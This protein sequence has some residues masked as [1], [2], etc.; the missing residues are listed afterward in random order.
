M[1]GKVNRI[2]EID[3][4]TDNKENEPEIV[5]VKDQKNYETENLVIESH[6]HN[7]DEI[8]DNETGNSI[9]YYENHEP[10]LLVCS[11]MQIND[12]IESNP[13]QMNIDPEEVEEIAENGN[14][15][16]VDVIDA[17]NSNKEADLTVFGEMLEAGDSTNSDYKEN[18]FQPEDIGDPDYIESDDSNSSGDSNGDKGINNEAEN[19]SKPE[20]KP[21]AVEKIR[22][23]KVNR[24]MGK[25]YK[26]VKGKIV[27]ARKLKPLRENCRTQCKNILSENVRMAIF[28]EYWA[29]GNHDRRVSFIAGLVGVQETKINRKKQEGKP[30]KNRTNTYSYK[31]C[32]Q[33]EEKKV[34]KTCFCNTLGETEKFVTCAMQN[35]LMTTSGAT[36]EDLRGKA[37]PPHK[38][39]QYKLSQVE[40][41]I[42][43]F[44]AYK[45]H[46]SRRDTNINYLPSHLNITTMYDLYREE[47]PDNPVSINI[48]SRVFHTMNLKFKKPKIDTCTKCDTLNAKIKCAENDTEKDQFRKEL[49]DH[50]KTADD[51]YDSKKKDKQMGL[52]D[53]KYL[54]FAFDLQQVLPTP[55]LT[56]SKMFYLRQLSTYN[57]TVHNCNNGK[58]S[59]FM[60][61]ECTASRGANE[62]ASCLY[63]FLQ[64]IPEGVEHAIFYSDTC[65]GQNK[66]S[67]VISMFQ[68]AINL[69]STLKI[70]DHKFLVPGHTHLECDVDHSII[71]RSKKRSP[72][73]IH[74]PRDW[75][76]LVRNASKKKNFTVF[77]MEIEHFYAFS[78]LQ[79]G[80]GP[81]QKKTNFKFKDVCWLRYTKSVTVNYKFSLQEDEPFKEVSFLR[82]GHTLMQL[83]NAE[84]TTLYEG[85]R[86]INPLKKQNL[87][88]IV[89]LLDKE[90]QY[91]YQNLKTDK[92]VDKDTDPDVDRYVSDEEE[93]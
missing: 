91:F 10:P 4:H 20:S 41:H 19:D 3:K 76:Q 26:T 60:W 28:R 85:P 93:S 51:A 38:T 15:L 24:N 81:L 73:E 79:S 47:Y 54:T 21:F 92:K 29:L 89:D 53:K 36:H 87:L 52:E 72:I 23:R 2:D 63:R 86:P 27:E 12:L 37:A 35:K 44:P 8:V 90:V 17:P 70:I 80:K 68:Y 25:E 1:A 43:S 67:I 16:E 56:S 32:V 55:F 62:I 61:P 69:H 13:Y 14:Q 83:K 39:P 59:H 6:Q 34:C 33:G 78:L 64:S 66:N 30:T 46:Y 84:L 82:K 42:K 57:L 45:S 77:P 9:I 31:F 88:E 75:Y 50:Q 18:S 40:K 7:E 48:Y 65:G 58:S 74:V 22:M 11:Q 5:H 71:E 49:E